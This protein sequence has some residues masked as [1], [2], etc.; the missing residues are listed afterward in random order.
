M[1]MLGRAA[2]ARRIAG[3]AIVQP[4]ARLR[5]GGAPKPQGSV[6]MTTMQ[7]IAAWSLAMLLLMLVLCWPHDGSA[8]VAPLSLA[9]GLGLMLAVMATPDR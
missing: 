2:A 4:V 3:V 9:L 1:L 6:G 7:R 5:R 8:W